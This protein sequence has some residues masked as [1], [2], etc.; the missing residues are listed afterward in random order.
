MVTVN[1]PEGRSVPVRAGNA[2]RGWTRFG[3]GQ[4]SVAVGRAANEARNGGRAAVDI[5]GTATL[6]CLGPPSR[7]APVV[8]LAELVYGREHVCMSGT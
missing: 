6:G 2:A 1:C 3:S 8:A 7:P 5:A 4:R